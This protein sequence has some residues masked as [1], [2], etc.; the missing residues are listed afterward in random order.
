MK[1]HNVIAYFLL[2]IFAVFGLAAF[3]RHEDGI[4]RLTQ[5]VTEIEI[6]TDMHD[7]MMEGMDSEDM[8]NMMNMMSG[9]MGESKNTQQG[10]SQAEHESHH[11]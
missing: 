10:D 9:M 7:G 5:V 4:A 3:T 2:A 11:E 1:N 8:K 6:K